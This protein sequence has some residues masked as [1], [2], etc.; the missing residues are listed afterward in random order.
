MFPQRR[1][2]QTIDSHLELIRL[3]FFLRDKELTSKEVIKS[4]DIRE[5]LLIAA[6]LTS[7]SLIGSCRRIGQIEFCKTFL[8]RF[9]ICF[10]RV[11][12]LF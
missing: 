12:K 10:C 11:L 2:M 7:G 6:S 5:F 8:R 3:R 1:L 4:E 9:V